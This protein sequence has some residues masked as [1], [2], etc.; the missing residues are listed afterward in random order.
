MYS[1][2]KENENSDKRTSYITFSMK[3]KIKNICKS[4]QYREKIVRRYFL[5]G[6]MSKNCIYKKTIDELQKLKKE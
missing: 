3:L 6:C 5:V 1:K 4:I 2:I